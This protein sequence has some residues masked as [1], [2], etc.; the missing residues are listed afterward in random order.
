MA[1]GIK[2]WQSQTAVGLP[3]LGVDFF[4]G[5]ESPEEVL[6]VAYSMEQG[7]GEFYLFMERQVQNRSAKALFARLA[8][9]EVKHQ[10]AIYQ[11][12]A[13]I[14]EKALTQSEFEAQVQTRAMEGGLS[15]EEYLEMFQLDLESPEDVICLAMSIEAQ[16]LDL[17]HRVSRTIEAES[18]RRIIEQIAN[19][20]KRH[21]ERLGELMET[22]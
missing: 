18:S 9:I 12:Y 15:T 5:S 20:E 4:W 17:Y 7:L 13:D 10:A 6:K 11:A 14:A 19:D 3:E 8:D 2:A 22:L 16:A 21:L 1:G